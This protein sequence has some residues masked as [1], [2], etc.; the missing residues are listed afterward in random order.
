MVGDRRTGVARLILGQEW[1][2]TLAK[3]RL[4]QSCLERLKLYEDEVRELS[5]LP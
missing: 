2:L 4:K 5:V 3:R 1:T